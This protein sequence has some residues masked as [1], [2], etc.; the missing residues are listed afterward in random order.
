MSEVLIFGGT[1]EGREAAQFCAEKGICADVC[2]ATEYGASLLP[3][4]QFLRIMTGRL[5]CDGMKALMTAKKYSMVIDATHPYAEEVT[6]NIKT[7]CKETGT[8]Y[9][10]LLRDEAEIGYGT[11]VTDMDELVAFLDRSD[12]VVL[13]TLGSKEAAK[14]TAVRDFAQRIWIRALPDEKL[15]SICA[16]MG[17]DKDKLILEK[18]PFTVEQNVTH[19]RQSGAEIVVT[20]ES[21]RAGGYTEKAEAARICGAELVTLA[22]PEEEGYSQAE[23]T[24]LLRKVRT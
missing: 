24:E 1:T 21:G 14:L 7:A 6:L 17:Y 16:D 2:V 3:V 5:D 4:S 13:S 19:I 9:Y 11:K 15:I 10:R 22:R 12:K 8:K 20:K 18:G 23:I